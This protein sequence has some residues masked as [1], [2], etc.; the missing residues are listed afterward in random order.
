MRRLGFAI[1][2]A[3]CTPESRLDRVTGA[4]PPPAAEVGSSSAVASAQAVAPAR[5][6]PAPELRGPMCRGTA[7][8][9]ASE[10]ADAPVA[11]PE[12]A[13]APVA[14]PAP[15]ARVAG[16]AAPVPVLEAHRP[17]AP[18]AQVTAAAPDDAIRTLAVTDDG[19][20]AVSVGGRG[21]MRLW[22]SLDG[23][24]EPVVVRSEVGAT[25]LA[26]ARDGSELVIAA[27]GA[28]GQLELI[29]TTALGVPLARAALDLGRGI[30]ALYATPRGF[31]GWRDDQTF[32]AVDLHGAWIEA[33]SSGPPRGPAGQPA[34]G[35]SVLAASPGEHVA[36][37]ASRRGRLLAFVDV[38]GRTRGRWIEV[39]DRLAW[40]SE[41]ATLPID[42]AHAVLA[43][44]LLRVAA[45][46][47]D[48]TDIVVVDLSR[49]HVIAR[50]R[51]GEPPSRERRPV[52][53]I[54]DRTLEIV[55][56]GM[57]GWWHAGALTWPGPGR[58]QGG[59]AVATDRYIVAADRGGL[60]LDRP[61]ASKVL[62]F[63]MASVVSA[64][65]SG[66]GW[67]V[68]GGATTLRLDDQF[69]ARG[70]FPV[71]DDLLGELHNVALLDAGHSLVRIGST[72]YV[73]DLA[74][75]DKLDVGR[76]AEGEVSYEPT[77][78]LLAIAG[79]HGL[80]LARYNPKR[81]ELDAEAEVTGEPRGIVL[82]DPELSGGKVALVLAQDASTA[83]ITEIRGI[84]FAAAVPL[85]EGR[86]YKRTLPELPEPQ[87][88]SG[89]AVARRLGLAPAPR[90]HVS[91]DGALVAIAGNGRIT[92][93][94]RDGAVRWSVAQ[95]GAVDVA[96]SSLGELV[97]FGSGM[98]RVDTA[99]RCAARSP[100]W[101]GA[102][103]A[104]RGRGRR[105]RCR[106]V[107]RARAARAA[108][109]APVS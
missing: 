60:R 73:I 109:A 51:R 69:R 35:R 24:R 2:L 64:Q 43:P 68:A 38:D 65:R 20:V 85:R 100:V 104:G 41:T 15:A 82:L 9:A 90:H 50:P 57:Q 66:H 54:D 93:R 91:P 63:A 101:L 27:G 37:L 78:H 81:H 56:E 80:W 59:S 77:T 3:A 106:A 19:G 92:L 102:R 21:G 89:D 42:P 29:R 107:R 55:D 23:K 17:A 79:E 16:S 95:P 67:V 99:T 53:F 46:T 10:P 22:P 25:Q 18:P 26:I 88:H 75:P 30:L 86:T 36:G 74:R 5:S 6:G 28:M 47:K 11:A 70:R 32:V 97:A 71:P 76:M 52:G 72:I 14:M 34:A 49:G 94:E 44:G 13:A 96:W 45:P 12:R 61:D 58:V 87:D 105:S 7:R 108:R 8:A 62:G 4:S 84:D 33:A 98:A 83:T 1:A 39:G 31:V 103:A 40:G 48:R